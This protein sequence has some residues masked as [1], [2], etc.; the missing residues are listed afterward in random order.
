MGK[1]MNTAT[2]VLDYLST[3]AQLLWLI[4]PNHVYLKLRPA[5][6]MSKFII[7]QKV[8]KSMFRLRTDAFCEIG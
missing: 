6:Q 2:A 8:D 7:L 4:L 1:V 3:N 5:F